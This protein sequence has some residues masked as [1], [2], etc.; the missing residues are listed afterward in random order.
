MKVLTK[1]TEK[2]KFV[3]EAGEHKIVMDAKSP[4]GNDTGMTPKHL[5][6]VASAAAREWMLFRC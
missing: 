2:M 3:A 5:L 1:W 4:I 6:L